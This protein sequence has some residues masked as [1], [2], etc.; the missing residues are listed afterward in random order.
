MN[1]EA[2]D[3]GILLP[4]FLTGLVVLATHVPLGRRVLERGIIF[5]DLAVAQIAALGVI[6]V[7]A[8]GLAHGGPV[9][10]LAAFAA[11]LLGALVL[12]RCDR[13][14][15]AIREALIGCA[16]VL[17]ATAALLL[18]G[19]P[20]LAEHLRDLLVGQILWV[21]LPRLIPAA[22]VSAAVLLLWPRM[23]GSLAGFYVL[24][25]VAVTTSVQLVGLYL[26]FA[27]LIFPALAVRGRARGTGAGLLLG[28]LGYALGLV[29]SAALDL[30]SGPAVVW[31]LALLTLPFALRPGAQT[32]AR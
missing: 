9:T 27:S 1:G 13:N 23:R 16:F 4:A 8:L 18:A 3:P 24:F 22:L 17:A 12:E 19:D 32:A 6:A 28:A 31:C 10:Q 7:H 30:P 2:L 15:P 14:W 25:A 29:L 5:I 11:A 21:D 26:V 20:G